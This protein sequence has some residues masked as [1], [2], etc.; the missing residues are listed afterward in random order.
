MGF[1]LL[2]I[3]AVSFFVEEEVVLSSIFGCEREEDFSDGGGCALLELDVDEAF[4]FGIWVLVEVTR[5]RMGVY[6]EGP[7]IVLLSGGSDD[8]DVLLDEDDETRRVSRKGSK[9]CICSDRN[10]MLPIGMIRMR[11]RATADRM[12]L[13]GLKQQKRCFAF[14]LFP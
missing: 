1:T 8:D 11:K 14:L 5:E 2:V 13:M 3:F 6:W 7:R 4:V 10:N 9:G 12:T